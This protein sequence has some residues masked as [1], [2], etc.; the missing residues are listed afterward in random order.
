MLNKYSATIPVITVIAAF[1]LLSISLFLPADMFRPMSNLAPVGPVSLFICPLLGVAGLIVSL[2]Q[3]KW[4]WV[5]ANV[6]VILAFLIVM[7]AGHLVVA[8]H[9][10][11]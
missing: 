8:F 2:M 11:T 3:K 6:S 4:K 5:L 10:T 7:L 1:V 9:M